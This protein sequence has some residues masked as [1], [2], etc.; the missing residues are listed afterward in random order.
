M[1]SDAEYLDYAARA[2]DYVAEWTAAGREHFLRDIRTQ[3]AVLYKLQTLTQALRDMTAERRALHPEVPF[4][5]MSGFRTVIVHDY[6][7]LDLDIIWSV[8][9]EHLPL[10]RPQVARMIA[11]L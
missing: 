9:V 6:L 1:R 5:I 11:E 2:I 10:L 3:A 4:K 7:S 8:V